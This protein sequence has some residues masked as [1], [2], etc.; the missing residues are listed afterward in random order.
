MM[1]Q[2]ES[3]TIPYWQ[4]PKV[5]LLSMM[6]IMSFGFGVWQVLLNNFVVERANFTGVEIG[7]LQSL[8][9]VPGFLAFTAVYLLLI[10]KEQYFALLS[11]AVL[12]AGIALTG[13][14]PFEYG[15]YFTTVV[16]SI[17]FHYFE[18]MNKSL[19]LQWLDKTETPAF[20]GRALKIKALASL[21]AYGLILLGMKWLGLDYVWMYLVVGVLGVLASGFIFV[22][23]KHFKDV[24]IQHKKLILRRRYWLYYVLVFLSGAR[25]QIFVVFAGFMMV[26]KFGYSVADI[27]LLFI[28][29]Y[30]FNF[31]FA[32][33]IGHLIGVM[34]ERRSLIIEYI[35]LIFVFAGYAFV[36]SSELAAALYVIDH[37]FFAF[38]IAISTYFQKIADKKDIA[39]TAS[40]SFT[41]NHIAA[42]VIPALL[43]MVWIYSHTA[44]FLVGVV[45]AVLSLL[46]SLNV[47]RHPDES[48]PVIWGHGA[49]G[50]QSS[51]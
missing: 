36:E 45:F 31:L 43:G 41:I 4:S 33:R 19:T 26:E 23:F 38:S 3:P 29:N 50:V 49:T 13:F 20:M 6:F 28:I 18:T 21:G 34:G 11:I 15:L 48:S 39:A 2:A 12:S 25:R 44:V 51:P 5:L 1:N 27:S 42:V 35:G 30:V 17:G 16:M 37:L 8:R 22:R 24:A 10:F 46:F 14:L 32:A 7:I 40:V 9:E 47:P